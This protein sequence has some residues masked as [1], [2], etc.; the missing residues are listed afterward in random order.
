MNRV[1]LLGNIGADP[2]LRMTAG[3]TAVLKFTMATSEKW[4][5]KGTGQ[6]KEETQWHRIVMWGQ[7]AETLAKML[8]KGQKVCV[9]G[10][11]KYG[12]YDDNAGV[13]RYTTDVVIDQLHFCGSKGDKQSGGSP[14][15]YGGSYAPN[16]GPADKPAIDDDDIPF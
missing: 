7:R 9:E 16:D 4:K 15:P 6:L 13:T 1:H 8:T 3:G 14:S 5:D 2:E 10:K 11:L 12:K